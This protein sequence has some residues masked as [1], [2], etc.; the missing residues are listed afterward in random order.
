MTCGI[1]RALERSKAPT[2]AISRSAINEYYDTPT[3][4]GIVLAMVWGVFA[5]LRR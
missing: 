2:G 4:A 5:L 1:I 3:R